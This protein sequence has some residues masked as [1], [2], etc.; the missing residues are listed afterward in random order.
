M[1]T[2]TTHPVDL[3]DLVDVETELIDLT[4]ESLTALRMSGTSVLS[5]AI[6][7]AVTD[8]QPGSDISAGFNN[9]L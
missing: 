5:H 1:A 8:A 9:K 4:D 3:Q 2:S 6:R 7:R